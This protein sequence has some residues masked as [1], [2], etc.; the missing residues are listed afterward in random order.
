V[1][2]SAKAWAGI[3]IRD[4]NSNLSPVSDFPGTGLPH[5]THRT[6]VALSFHHTHVSSVIALGSTT[7]GDDVPAGRRKRVENSCECCHRRKV[8]CDVNA[9]GPPCTNCKLDTR[10]CV[11]RV[12][13]KR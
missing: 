10:Q 5:S 7:M 4:S 11:L 3:V 13:L 9:H 6:D 1:A 12:P 2:R 8:R